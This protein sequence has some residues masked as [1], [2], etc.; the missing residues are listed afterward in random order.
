M[1]PKRNATELA[2]GAIEEAGEASLAL[3]DGK[4]APV[5]NPASVYLASLSTEKSRRTQWCSLQRVLKLIN[6]PVPVDQFP[7]QS[8]RYEHLQFIRTK[9][10]ESCA[11]ATANLSLAALRRVMR[12]A[13]R[14]NLIDTDTYHRTVDIER[15]RG[16]R[17][18]KG[19]HVNSG[20][21]R[22]LYEACATYKD[23]WL[24]AR[25]A[26]MLSLLFGL[27][28]RRA[29]AAALR[30]DQVDLATGT[31]RMMGKGNKERIGYLPPGA[32]DAIKIWIERFRPV[33]T[34]SKRRRAVERE[35]KLL[36][37]TVLLSAKHGLTNA[38]M[39]ESGILYSL[40]QLA[41]RAG[42]KPFSPHDLRRTLIGEL[43]DAGVD[44]VTV[45]NIVGHSSP[46]TTGRYDRRGERAKRSAATTVFIPYEEKGEDD[47]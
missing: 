26:A 28:M 16:S 10:G 29:E 34:A 12:A 9:L 23:P 5:P 41:K 44:I 11:P 1:E 42:V 38:S 36:A 25:N 22:A 32:I 46:T 17:E 30:I 6:V 31:V 24:G 18:V 13:W 37:N 8:L 47:E 2:L 21:I 39:S 43:L 3:S 45:Q 20:E 40:N 27:G 19:R 4:A 33:V 14:L 7:W 15:V 35:P